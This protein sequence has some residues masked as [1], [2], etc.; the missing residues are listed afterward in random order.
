MACTPLPQVSA[1]ELPAPLSIDPPSV[2]V[3]FDAA[4]CCKIIPFAAATPP[5][6]LPPLTL[7]PAVNAI[8]TEN[9]ALVQAFLDSLPLECP[10][11]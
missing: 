5:I 2:S 1:P 11:E 3:E 9:I 6:P 4:M 7:N 8:I 10:K